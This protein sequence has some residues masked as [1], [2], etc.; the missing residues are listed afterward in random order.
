MQLVENSVLEMYKTQ[1]IPIADVVTPNP[2]EAQYL[3]GL[4]ITNIDSTSRDR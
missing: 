3:T 2:P 1:L 4:E